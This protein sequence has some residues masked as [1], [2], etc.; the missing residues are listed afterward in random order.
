MQ[1]LTL[2]SSDLVW[3]HRFVEVAV[4]GFDVFVQLAW[5][6]TTFICLLHETGYFDN[7]ELRMEGIIC[8]SISREHGVQESHLLS[9]R[10]ARTVF[11][12][13]CA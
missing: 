1:D 7:M 12:L 10:S 4:I 2:K 13:R 9:R 3:M 6:E 5:L 8:R 11:M